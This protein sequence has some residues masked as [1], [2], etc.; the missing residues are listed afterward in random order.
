MRI[1]NLLHIRLTVPRDL[2]ISANATT[3]PDLL[4][5][6]DGIDHLRAFNYEAKPR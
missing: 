2:L 6:L 3:W 5:V 4:F 1:E